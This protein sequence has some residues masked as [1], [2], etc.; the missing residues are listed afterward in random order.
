VIRDYKHN[1]LY[2]A[3]EAIH[4][5]HDELLVEAMQACLYAKWQPQEIL[6][7]YEARKQ[8]PVDPDKDQTYVGL[9]DVLRFTADVVEE[10][11]FM[12]S[13]TAPNVAYVTPLTQKMMSGP[14]RHPDKRSESYAPQR[15]KRLHSTMSIDM[16]LDVWG[17]KQHHYRA[18]CKGRPEKS[19]S[20][21]NTLRES[22]R[23]ALQQNEDYHVE[24]ETLQE[25][26]H[27]NLLPRCLKM[28]YPNDLI[29]ELDAHAVAKHNAR[30]FTEIT[31]AKQ[32]AYDM[33]VQAWIAGGK[34]GTP[35]IMTTLSNTGRAVRMDYLT[36]DLAHELGAANGLNRLTGTTPKAT[37]AAL[38]MARVS[39]TRLTLVNKVHDPSRAIVMDVTSYYTKKLAR[40]ARRLKEETARQQA[41]EG[42]TTTTTGPS[43]AA[44]SAEKRR[45]TTTI[46]EYDDLPTTASLMPDFHGHQQQQPEPALST[47]HSVPTPGYT[48]V[49]G[50]VVLAAGLRA[51]QLPHATTANNTTTTDGFTSLS[52]STSSSAVAPATTTRPSKKAP[53]Q[54]K[55][56]LASEVYDANSRAVLLQSAS[57][58]FESASR[59]LGEDDGDDSRSRLFYEHTPI[60]RND[61]DMP[62]A[63]LLDD[64]DNA[65]ENMDGFDDDDDMDM[66]EDM[67]DDGGG[68]DDDEGDE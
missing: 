31:L 5:L 8:N 54:K 59:L 1:M 7:A 66:D 15:E 64:D 16:D 39:G 21:P 49:D 6:T 10:F 26:K 22:V 29:D 53:P 13:Y 34:V 68:D 55:P 47:V 37:A 14:R 45:K 36:A 51:R 52:S 20:Y 23:R 18:G 62:T 3:T 48:L 30:P 17:H 27:V 11:A 41:R 33:E 60:V 32:Q 4:K 42:R 43:A 40:D 46:N 38:A 35:P 12:E 28:K 19:P 65:L 57:V 24:N 9:F 2:A 61:D 58:G 50:R 44:A 67:D 25:V 63:G 56:K